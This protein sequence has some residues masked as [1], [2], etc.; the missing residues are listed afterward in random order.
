MASS[1]FPVVTLALPDAAA[2][3]TFGGSGGVSSTFTSA[4]ARS[5]WVKPA[6]AYCA[7][8]SFRKFTMS[9]LT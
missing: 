7:F 5:F 3:S 6:L 9:P 4:S 2:T 8:C 1:A